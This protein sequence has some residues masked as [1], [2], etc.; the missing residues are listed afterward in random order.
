MA[1]LAYLKDPLNGITRPILR[2]LILKFGIQSSKQAFKDELQEVLKDMP[3]WDILEAVQELLYST[4]DQSTTTIP[5]DHLVVSTVDQELSF[6]DALPFHQLLSLEE[7]NDDCEED[8]GK[9][10]CSE[11]SVIDSFP[12]HQLLSL[13]ELNDDNEEDHGEVLCSELSLIDL[14]PFHQLISSEE[15]NDDSSAQVIDSSGLLN[16]LSAITGEEDHRKELDVSSSVPWAGCRFKSAI[17]DL[18]IEK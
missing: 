2:K 4:S 15:L 14:L 10:L 7:L 5:I 18:W 8:H 9:E 13:E 11:S 3:L 12:F 6:I 16:S 1:T 17:L